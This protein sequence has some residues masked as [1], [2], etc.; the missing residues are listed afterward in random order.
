MRGSGRMGHKN[1]Y[2]DQS[3]MGC[4][5]VKY[6]FNKEQFTCSD[7]PTMRKCILPFKEPACALRTRQSRLTQLI[8]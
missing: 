7:P 1:D 6:V 5:Q 3:W 2:S 8:I 4:S